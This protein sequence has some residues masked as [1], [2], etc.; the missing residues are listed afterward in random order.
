MCVPCQNLPHW[1]L[2]SASAI[3]LFTVTLPVSMSHAR[4]LWIEDWK[5]LIESKNWRRITLTRSLWLSGHL[6][7][8]RSLSCL[9]LG[10]IWAVKFWKKNYIIVKYRIF[11]TA[12][13]PVYKSFTNV[14]HLVQESATIRFNFKKT[15]ECKEEI[16]IWTF[17]IRFSRF[18]QVFLIS[19]LPNNICR[20]FW[21]SRVTDL[22]DQLRTLVLLAITPKEKEEG[23]A[24]Q[25][26]EI[27]VETFLFSII[28]K[29]SPYIPKEVTMTTMTFPQSLA[30]STGER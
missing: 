14:S 22:A 11:I 23:G 8:Q 30:A 9:A 13:T 21:K 12:S 20:Y 4:L 25:R 19:M 1:N 27:C 16:R 24:S 2:F 29:R 5:S 18:F 28:E 7:W 10:K 17:S 3:P 15:S 6:Y 26:G